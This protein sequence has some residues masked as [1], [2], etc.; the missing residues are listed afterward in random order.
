MKLGLIVHVLHIFK[1]MFWK[2]G[3]QVRHFHAPV[4]SQVCRFFGAVVSSSAEE[5]YL[6]AELTHLKLES[7]DKHSR[8]ALLSQTGLFSTLCSFICVH[9]HKILTLFFLSWKFQT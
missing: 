8:L 2:C 5:S 7:G 1:G 9:I 6:C 3:S 4:V